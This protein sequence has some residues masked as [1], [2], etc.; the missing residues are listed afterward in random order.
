MLG[1][2]GTVVKLESWTQIDKERFNKAGTKCLSQ[3]SRDVFTL[4]NIL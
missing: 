4:L 3:Q 2:S 1:Q